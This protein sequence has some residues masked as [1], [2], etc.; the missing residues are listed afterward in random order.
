MNAGFYGRRA[1]DNAAKRKNAEVEGVV[2]FSRERPRKLQLEGRMLRLVEC[3]L[4]KLI[5]RC[6]KNAEPSG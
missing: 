3:L 1:E 2:V 5:L 4:R 6:R